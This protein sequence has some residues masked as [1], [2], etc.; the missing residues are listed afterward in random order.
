MINF[1]THLKWMLIFEWCVARCGSENIHEKDM[2][3]NEFELQLQNL[4]TILGS[5]GKYGWGESIREVTTTLI[6]ICLPI[7]THRLFH[8]SGDLG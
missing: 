1:I 8:F 7:R 4:L 6:W 3:L 2:C 5:I